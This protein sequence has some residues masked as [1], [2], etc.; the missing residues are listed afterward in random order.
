MTK[1]TW[2]K[3]GT[4]VRSLR[5]VDGLI[6]YIDF[7]HHSHSSTTYI[8]YIINQLCFHILVEQINSK[9]P[10]HIYSSGLSTP[11]GFHGL[12][13]TGVHYKWIDIKERV[14]HSN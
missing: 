11:W 2:V 8:W 9:E 12:S 3:H 14:V 4:I 5:P 13:S 1:A 10:I 6:M 7:V